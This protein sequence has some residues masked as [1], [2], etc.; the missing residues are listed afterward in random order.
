MVSNGPTQAQIL[1]MFGIG[2]LFEYCHG[3]WKF[4]N[5]WF[6]C[7]NNSL[8][9]NMSNTAININ[10][11]WPNMNIC[12]ASWQIFQILNHCSR[13]KSQAI[14][15]TIVQDFNYLLGEKLRNKLKYKVCK[16]GLKEIHTVTEIAVRHRDLICITPVNCLYGPFPACFEPVCM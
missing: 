9:S 5:F 13:L 7:Q 12:K 3:V 2:T 4:R 8:P 1:R 16:D 15:T 14:L 6:C 10:F 11:Q